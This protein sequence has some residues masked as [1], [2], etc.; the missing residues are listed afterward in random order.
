MAYL[1]IDGL[2]QGVGPWEFPNLV[3]AAFYPRMSSLSFRYA[4]V[5][6]T[7]LHLLMCGAAGLLS[8]PLLARYVYRTRRCRLAGLLVGLGWYYLTFRFFWPSVNPKLVALQPFPGVL[9]A[10]ILFGICLGL[11]PFYVRANGE[12]RPSEVAGTVT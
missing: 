5:A 3:A 7:A 4:T 9:F 1:M 12:V 10:H 6:G 8:Y 2:W 11:Y